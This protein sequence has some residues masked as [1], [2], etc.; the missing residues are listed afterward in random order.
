MITLSP[1]P[2]VDLAPPAVGGAPAGSVQ[3][4]EAVG[5]VVGARTLM[6]IPVTMQV[7]GSYAALTQFV[8]QLEGLQRSMLITDVAISIEGA[9]Q[10]EPGE[11]TLNL[12]AAVFMTAQPAAVEAVVPSPNPA[13]DAAVAE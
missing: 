7:V 11:L 10:A 12:G 1:S 13:A 4:A 5:S 8:T 9:E 6:Q 2:P 3:P